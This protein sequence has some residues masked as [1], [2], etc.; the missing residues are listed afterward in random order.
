MTICCLCQSSEVS[1]FQ[2]A[3]FF[4]CSDCHLIFKNSTLHLSAAD[5]KIRYELHENN[6]D[7]PA[8]VRFLWPAVEQVKKLKS[9]P[10]LGLDFGCGP[11]P[12]LSQLLIQENYQMYSYDPIFFTGGLA[13][14]KNQPQKIFDFITCTEAAEHFYKPGTEF[15]KLFSWIKAGGH[16]VLMTDLFTEN[17]ILQNWGYARD[18]S[19]VCFFSEKTFSWL[20]KK[21]SA[22]L[23]MISSR[24]VCF[25]L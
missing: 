1:I 21:Y 10:G 8:Y 6:I 3:A 25:T 5:E 2:D 24:L 18:P 22:E 9:P 7:D 19:H 12:V 20:A 15:K 23:E 4:R 17:K 11:N 16:L 13:D 14:F